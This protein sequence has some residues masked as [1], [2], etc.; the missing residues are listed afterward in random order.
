VFIRFNK[1]QLLVILSLLLAVLLLASCGSSGIG[2]IPSGTPDHGNGTP[3]VIPAA[4][5]TPQSI[6]TAPPGALGATYA[7]VRKNQL[8]VALNG[9]KP[10]QV[11]HFN[12][13]NVPDV[14][15][16]QPLWS[17]DDHFIAFIMNA[18]PIGQGGGGCPAPDYG[19]NG[20][21]YL[22]NTSNLRLTQLVE[23]ADSNDPMALNGYWQYVFWEDPMH[24]LAWYNG[25][26]GKTSNTAGLYRYDL[27]NKRLTQ[28]IP[29]ST[30]GVATLFNARQNVPL[31]LSMRYSSGQLYYQVIAHPFEQQSQ[32]I[33]YRHSVLQPA[34][35]GNKVVDM[36]S[37]PWCNPQ[38][39]GPFILPGWD[40]APDGEQ[41][42]AQM[43]AATGA[44]LPVAS[45]Q[46]LDLNDGSTTALFTQASPQMLTHDLSLTWGPDSQAVVATEDHMLNQDGPFSATLADPAAMQRYVPNLAGQVAWRADSKA[47]VLQNVDATDA[48]DATGLYM[49]TTGDPHGQFLLTDAQDFV[50]G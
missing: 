42:V 3:A 21:L 7:F 29:L 48:T 40:V 36:G 20:A 26:I 25:T 32:F 30:L 9:S 46:A 10:V 38:Q 35:P 19:A 43:I 50:W 41:L 16:H 45:I 47:F 39:S 4:S 28:V 23:S 6:L 5:P 1:L 14:F 34:L 24:L 15:W 13:I 12:Y 8:W 31:L 2:T 11:T 27:S 49:F 22:L 18:R 37:E 33:I 44:N 17:P